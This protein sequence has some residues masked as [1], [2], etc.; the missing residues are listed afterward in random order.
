MECFEHPWLLKGF[1]TL[2]C[3]PARIAC[4]VSFDTNSWTGRMLHQ[5]GCTAWWNEDASKQ[6]AIFGTDNV[7]GTR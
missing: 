1:D 4:I 7:R 2:V 3:L 6:V 5:R